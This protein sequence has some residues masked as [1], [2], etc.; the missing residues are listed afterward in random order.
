[1]APDLGSL[2]RLESARV[3]LKEA[4]ALRY[5]GPEQVNLSDFSRR[6]GF[7]SRSYLSELLSGKKGFSR[8]S[9][10]RIRSALR[11]PRPW[12]DYFEVLALM[13]SPTLRGRKATPQALGAR[14]RKL[15]QLMAEAT[16]PERKELGRRASRIFGS[17]ALFQVYSA[18]GHTETGATLERILQRTRLSR[19]TVRA[20]LGQ[21]S[22]V[23][24]ARAAGDRYFAKQA[25]VDALGLREEEGLARLIS[26]A[27]GVLRARAREIIRDETNLV[28][29]TCLSVQSH[30]MREFREELRGAVY[31]VF[32]KY[33]ADEGDQVVSVLVGTF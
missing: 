30:R 29:F 9:I 8:D 27:A 31:E 21:L 14:A 13:E 4:L 1:M 3:F 20:A 11:L 24:L 16:D 5:G 18:L 23:G 26:E 2:I 28:F 17:P 15:Q 6:A 22:S 33:Q 32:E 12:L 10:G 25:R 19:A 7:S